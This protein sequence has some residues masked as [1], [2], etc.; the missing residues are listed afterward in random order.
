MIWFATVGWVLAGIAGAF[1]IYCGMQTVPIGNVKLRVEKSLRIKYQD[2][3][4][5]LCNIIDGT[6]G[7][8]AWKGTGVCVDDV[9]DAVKSLVD[10]NKDLKNLAE[11]LADPELS[12]ADKD[13]LA[14]MYPWLWTASA[15]YD[16]YED[17]DD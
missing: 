14:R 7:G 10:E 15:A 6:T 8:H 5:K 3:V 9:V 17:C 2:I 12:P 11:Q 1:A 4:Y 13:T 16:D